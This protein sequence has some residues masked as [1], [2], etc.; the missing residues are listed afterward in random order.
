MRLT[1]YYHKFVH[2]YGK[3]SAPLTRLLKKGAFAWDVEAE[4][5]FNSLKIAMTLAPV[6]AMPDFSKQFSIEFDA[7]GVGISVKLMQ[8]DRPIAFTS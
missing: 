1:G 3:I 5:A 8:E 7:S 2:D 4:Q 6:L